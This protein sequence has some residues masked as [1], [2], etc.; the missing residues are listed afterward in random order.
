MMKPKPTD[1]NREI[2]ER[3]AERIMCDKALFITSFTIVGGYELNTLWKEDV[4][5]IIMEELK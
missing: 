3:I 5:Q 2:A 1:H 4:I